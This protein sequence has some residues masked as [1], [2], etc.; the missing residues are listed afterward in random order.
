MQIY[1]SCQRGLGKKQIKAEKTESDDD[2]EEE[3]VEKR[4]NGKGKKGYIRG[5]Q[6]EI[7]ADR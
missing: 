1:S 5:M 2:E 4:R 7:W 3:E 6:E